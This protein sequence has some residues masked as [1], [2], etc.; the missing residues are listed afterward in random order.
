MRI[1]TKAWAKELDECDSPVAAAVLYG[2]NNDGLL[3]LA[4]PFCGEQ[5]IHG[6]TPGEAANLRAGTYLGSKSSHCV[7]P[8]RA[9][10]SSNYLLVLVKP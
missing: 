10:M 4:C 9:G 2:T 1:G 5:H 3:V 6:I 7:R 8:K